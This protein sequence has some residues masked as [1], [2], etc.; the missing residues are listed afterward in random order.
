MFDFSQAGWKAS[1]LKAVKVALWIIASAGVSALIEAV[2]SGTFGVDPLTMGI[3]N[4]V[5]AAIGKWI[6]TKKPE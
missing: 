2:K 3:A 1:L 5:L 4:I 6:T